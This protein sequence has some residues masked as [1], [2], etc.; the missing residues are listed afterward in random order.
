M[1]VYQTERGDEAGQLADAAVDGFAGDEFEA[2]RLA[3]QEQ[4][5]RHILRQPL[6]RNA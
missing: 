4:Q 2:D 3:A 6:I 1:I 5:V